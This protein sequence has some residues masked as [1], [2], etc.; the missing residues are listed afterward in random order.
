M[1]SYSTWKKLLVIVPV[2][3]ITVLHYLTS[4]L[5]AP[6][7]DIYRRLYYLPIVLG[8]LWFGLRGGLLTAAGVS[9][10]YLPHVLLQW[11]PQSGNVLEQ[12]LEI[13]LY[14]IVGGLTGFLA[15]RE[16]RQKD[17]YRLTA[18]RLERSYAQLREQADALLAVE[19]QLR[20][21]ERLSTLGEM[22]ASLAHEIRNPLGSIR[23][24]AEVVTDG[25]PADDRR[26]EFGR[27]LVKEVT[28]L[29]QVLEEFLR[30][31]RPQ[32]DDREPVALCELL[33]ELAQQLTP[34][35]READ[36]MVTVQ[37]EPTTVM[38]ARLPLQ[39]ALLNLSLNGIQAMDAGGRLELSLERQGEEVRLRVTDTGPG[40]SSEQLSHIFD[41]FYT[42][43]AEGTGLGLTIT[44]RLVQR[45]GGKLSVDSSLGVG[46]SF[47]IQLS[48]AED[49]EGK[50]DG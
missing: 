36:V 26:Q 10:L 34:A 39:Q 44:S 32:A 1:P 22:S 28:R 30:M 41:P 40:M 42:T 33:D 11:V 12:V 6:Y 25:L 3:V 16:Q 19:E 18:A 27:I 46:T 45:L 35:A 15:E 50:H 43:R 8:A 14:N 31:A 13:M 2:L 37:G 20:L 29:N 7:H 17:L 23:M 5:H 4:T 48:A 24:A 9:L 21:S 47:V 49:G 38:A